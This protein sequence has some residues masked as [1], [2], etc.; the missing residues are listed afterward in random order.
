MREAVADLAAESANSLPF[1]PWC[2][3][4]QVK[5][6][7]FPWVERSVYLERMVWISSSGDVWSVIASIALFESV[8][9]VKLGFGDSI[10]SMYSSA[11]FM[12]ISSLV[13]TEHTLLIFPDVIILFVVAIA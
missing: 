3:G 7:V 6:M 2:E 13:K 1:I 5:E 9:M 11:F 10:V 8:S 12:A 4:I